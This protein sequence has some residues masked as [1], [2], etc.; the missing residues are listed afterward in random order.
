MSTSIHSYGLYRLKIE[1]KNLIKQF[2]KTQPKLIRDTDHIDEIYEKIRKEK[3]KNLDSFA[4][5]KIIF[6]IFPIKIK[7]EELDIHYL[8][9]N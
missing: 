3:F 7:M 2:L 6:L 5:L 4:T 8:I 1:I 9:I